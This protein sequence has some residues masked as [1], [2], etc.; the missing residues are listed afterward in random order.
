MSVITN[1][2]NPGTRKWA[3]DLGLLILRCGTAFFMLPHGWDKIQAYSEKAH[4]FYNFLHLGGEVSMALTIF[5]EFLCSIFLFIGLGTRLV[6]IPLILTMSVVVF[7]INATQPM[8]DKEEGFLYLIPYVVLFF[9]GPGRISF[10]Q[11]LFRKKKV[12]EVK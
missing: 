6:L 10:D 2:L 9:T 11:L 4:G 1:S 8:G 5:A 3:L 7:I 12:A